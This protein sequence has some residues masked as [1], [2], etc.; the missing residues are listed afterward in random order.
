MEKIRVRKHYFVLFFL[1]ILGLVFS[2]IELFKNNEASNIY[3][4]TP[5]YANTQE[6]INYEINGHKHLVDK[7][8]MIY[9]AIRYVDADWKMNDLNFPEVSMSA[10]E[11]DEELA[12]S[13]DV[14]VGIDYADQTFYLY[15]EYARAHYM[16]Y[17]KTFFGLLNSVFTPFIKIVKCDNGYTY[18]GYTIHRFTKKQTGLVPYS[19]KSELID[20]R[21][22]NS[23]FINE[24]KVYGY[25]NGASVHSDRS[26]LIN[27]YFTKPVTFNLLANPEHISLL[28][29]DG[30]ENIFF[31]GLFLN[32]EVKITKQKE[33]YQIKA[34]GEG[35]KIKNNKI[36]KITSSKTAF[37][38]V[39]EGYELE[40]ENDFKMK[41][42]SHKYHFYRLKSKPKL[43]DIYF[44][45][46]INVDYTQGRFY[47]KIGDYVS[48]AIIASQIETG[49]ATFVIKDV[50]Y[51]T[52]GDLSLFYKNIYPN[53]FCGYMR[54]DS[55]YINDDI[56]TDFSILTNQ[57]KD[58][59]L[60]KDLQVTDDIYYDVIGY[61]QQYHKVSYSSALKGV[62]GLPETQYVPFNKRYVVSSKAPEVY[63]S[64]YSFVGYTYKKLEVIDEFNIHT[65]CE[66]RP[67]FKREVQSY[68]KDYDGEIFTYNGEIYCDYY[69]EETPINWL[70]I[71]Y[72]PQ[73]KGMN[74]YSLYGWYEN[75][76]Y[77]PTDE[78]K[79]SHPSQIK[80]GQTYYGCWVGLGSNHKIDYYTNTNKDVIGLTYHHFEEYYSSYY[81]I[82]ENDELSFYSYYK[83]TS[84]IPTATDGTF[85]GWSDSKDSN[86]V[87][88]QAGDVFDDY[89]GN[90]TFYAVWEVKEV[91]LFID[92]KDGQIDGKDYLEIKGHP[93]EKISLS[94][95]TLQGYSF[96]AYLHEEGLTNEGK[97]DFISVDRVRQYTYTFGY[98]DDYIYTTYDINTYKFVVNLNQSVSTFINIK[99]TILVDGVE[100]NS[101]N[102]DSYNVHYLSVDA[103]YNSDIQVNVEINKDNYSLS[104][105]SYSDK[106]NKIITYQ[107]LLN[108]NITIDLY[109][110]QL[111]KITFDDNGADNYKE[112]VKTITKIHG[113]DVDVSNIPNPYKIE[114]KENDGWSISKD[115]LAGKAS[116]IKN[117][118]SITLYSYWKNVIN[119]YIGKDEVYQSIIAP[120]GDYIDIPVNPIKENYTFIGWSDKE[121]HPVAKWTEGKKS[122]ITSNWY[123]VYQGYGEFEQA[124]VINTLTVKFY[125]YNSYLSSY[126]YVTYSNVFTTFNYDL[127]SHSSLD[128]SNA[129][130]T[131]KVRREYPNLPLPYGVVGYNDDPNSLEIK[132]EGGI[133]E[134]KEDLTWYA[135]SK[136]VENKEYEITT[137]THKFHVN[138]NKY[139]SFETTKKT[140]ISG[141]VIYYNYDR[142]ISKVD[143][144]DVD[145]GDSSYS[146]LNYFDYYM[147]DNSFLGWSSDSLSTTT[148]ESFIRITPH[149]ELNFYAIYVIE[150][151]D[152]HYKDNDVIH[153][154]IVSEDESF[155]VVTNRRYY[156][157]SLYTTNYTKTNKEFS[158]T[159][160]SIAKDVI[161]KL[162]Y[163]SIDSP[164]ENLHF[165][166]WSEKANLSS[167]YD[168]NKI[169]K[170]TGADKE[171]PYGSIWYAVYE[172][173][174]S[175]EKVKEVNTTFTCYF[176][177]NEYKNVNVPLYYNNDGVIKAYNY[178]L[179]NEV[180]TNEGYFYNKEYGELIFPENVVNDDKIVGWAL[181]K[182][183]LDNYYKDD[184]VIPFDAN[185]TYYAVYEYDKDFTINYS[186][187]NEHGS[188]SK[189]FTLKGLRNYKSDVFKIISN[190]YFEFDKFD[191]IRNYRI[192]GWLDLDNQVSYEANTKY[193]VNFEYNDVIN[194]L[195][196]YENVSQFNVIDLDNNE[197]KIY[198]EGE[199]FI[200]P[201]YDNNK[202]HFTFAGYLVDET[203]Y[204]E[205]ESIIVNSD[206]NYKALLIEDIKY[207]VYYEHLDQVFECYKNEQITLM[208]LDVKENHIF[209]GYIID[210]VL[211][212][213]G[214]KIIVDKDL[215]IKA[216]IV[217]QPSF[218][219]SFSDEGINE[220][221]YIGEVITLKDVTDKDNFSCYMVNGVSYNIGDTIT[222]SENLFIEKVYKNVKEVKDRQLNVGLLI[223]YIAIGVVLLAS[224]IIF[225]IIL[226]KK[227]SKNVK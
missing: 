8:Q 213:I 63:P 45:V 4:K 202:E 98:D 166:G 167:I 91:S 3:S 214:D 35:H 2:N 112:S 189:T 164:Y 173:E 81:F 16:E 138:E 82:N 61:V 133:I 79:I 187:P 21:K 64:I 209:N 141:K 88:H 142:S 95:P 44:K 73:G 135:I 10:V 131:N 33:N 39:N 109:L 221:Y 9:F 219:V 204:Q 65:T 84:E 144:N 121:D 60:I 72:L 207:N 71:N 49:E 157:K 119:F 152:E 197:T 76:I 125:G 117:N 37:F 172:N 62:E 177:N 211:Y 226:I 199:E 31:D 106:E 156:Y 59:P 143:E 32:S 7:S 203:L 115:G 154:F 116:V 127:S 227:K 169:W 168:V 99:M 147:Y 191:N 146:E 85:I 165:I 14:I 216:D 87:T 145:Y 12:K 201:K 55:S 25:V 163:Q 51:N 200:F 129:I 225:I 41:L 46:H 139:Y 175:I 196:L 153:T 13:K 113:F 171:K 218:I 208:D 184:R 83:V 5:H 20:P 198:Y 56:I 17:E 149:E 15:D 194:L 53:V 102:K 126:D 30:G 80:E 42:D 29:E 11:Y 185:N 40:I 96:K 74:N 77:K 134:L 47:A 176:S 193:Y 215:Y 206:I 179:S 101:V 36:T 22:E 130:K 26:V 103:L 6:D 137:L 104:F 222:V 48:E 182:I 159:S 223:T 205:N 183:D 89:Y 75:P 27:L 1:F 148:D 28:D 190:S 123:A 58:Y 132:Y 210:D 54:I 174:G 124:E 66:L 162:T 78:G 68:F 186:L 160:G 178:N 181:S 107:T 114:G 180:I 217:E 118:E 195:A 94:N 57:D 38:E 170:A 34:T 70:D 128:F 140:P 151:N 155:E 220:R 212:Q 100:K 93:R 19:K 86:V 110:A 23:G 43:Y 18:A 120:S 108:D 188:D 150:V 92:L 97:L 161:D 69:G 24:E 224:L 136:T 122:A 52:K 111:Y 50:P 192:L 105:D 90:M 158:S 67:I